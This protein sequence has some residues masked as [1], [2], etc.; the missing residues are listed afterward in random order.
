VEN[1]LNIAAIGR[2][3]KSEE[4]AWLEVELLARH[5]LIFDA[6]ERL[7]NVV[8]A[9]TTQSFVRSLSVALSLSL[10]TPL[11]TILVWVL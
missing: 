2:D 5:G 3:K 9:I 7:N 10:L 8:R 6:Q 11:V 1:A 4:C